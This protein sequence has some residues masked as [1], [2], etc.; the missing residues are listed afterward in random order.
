[1][2]PNEIQNTDWILN[3]DWLMRRLCKQIPHGLG[4]IMWFGGILGIPHLE[5]ISSGCRKLI[6]VTRCILLTTPSIHNVF[7][8]S[9]SGALA[10][11]LGGGG[12]ECMHTCPH[13]VHLGVTVDSNALLYVFLFL[14]PTDS[15]RCL[16]C[17][18]AEHLPRPQRGCGRQG[19]WEGGMW[20]SLLSRH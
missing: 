19:P 7:S 3:A 2:W 9:I 8:V 15:K 18:L 16:P 12:T 1:M 17:E 5:Y 13:P 20:A 14:L 6:T 10:T 4:D 11:A